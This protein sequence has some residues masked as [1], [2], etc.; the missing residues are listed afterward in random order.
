MTDFEKIKEMDI[1]EILDQEEDSEIN[2][3]VISDSRKKTL[4]YLL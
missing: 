2:Y 1:D 4:S 3:H